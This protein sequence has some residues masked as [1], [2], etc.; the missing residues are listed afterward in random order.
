M[1]Y[2]I[3]FLFLIKLFAEEVSYGEKV[4]TGSGCYGC[5]GIDGGGSGN[6]PAIANRSEYYLI[7]KL[8]AYKNDEIKTPN[9]GVMKPF[10]E[11]L[12]ESEMKDVAKYLAN[13][14]N[15]IKTDSYELGFDPWDGGGS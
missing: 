15:H 10:A 7:N 6:Y 1:K 11:S 9:A 8:K 12:S 2:S 3:I 14:K 13:M 5:H 4:Y